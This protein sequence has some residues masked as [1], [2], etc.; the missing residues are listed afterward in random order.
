M[1][2]MEK[3]W[4]FISS[5]MIRLIQASGFGGFGSN[6]LL[7]LLCDPRDKIA[8]VRTIKRN[9]MVSS[10]FFFFIAT[11]LHLQQIES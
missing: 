6:M 10:R 7:I 5:P 4:I 9:S 2:I 8:M 11:L 1:M 3:A